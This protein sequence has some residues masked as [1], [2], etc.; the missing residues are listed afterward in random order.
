MSSRLLLNPL[1]GAFALAVI[2]SLRLGGEE[3]PEAEVVLPEGRHV[4]PNRGFGAVHIWAEHQREMAAVGMMDERDVPLYVLR[5]L[6]S[7]TPLIHEGASW[8]VTR[9]L[10]VR[11]ASG[12]AV[13]EFRARREGAVWTV[14]TAFSGTKTHGTRVGTVR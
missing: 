2:P 11:A 7:G 8:R 5:M 3:L 14:V 1:T 12:T 13:L 4:G 9:L 6:R 10:A